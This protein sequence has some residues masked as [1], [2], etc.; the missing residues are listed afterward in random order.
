MP[1][2]IPS[3]CAQCRSRCGVTA[4]VEDGRLVGI[5]AD[6]GHPSGHKICPKGRAAPELVYAPERLLWPLQRTNPKGAADPGWQRISW[7]QA[8]ATTAERLTGLKARHGARGVAFAITSP[9]ATAISDAIPWVERLVHA[10]GSPN[11]IYGTEICNWHK[12]EVPRFT[13]GST[14][15]VPDYARSRCILLWGHNPLVT[16]LAQAGEVQ[17]GLRAGAKLIVVD[18]RPAGFARRADSWL[19]VRPGS[20]GALA[21]GL[22]NLLIESKRIDH[23]FL[24][25][26]TNGPF[27]MREDDGSLLR[28]G[29]LGL[30]G[31]PRHYV[32][33]R[34]GEGGIARYDAVRGLWP[35]EPEGLAPDDLSL[36]GA[37]VHPGAVG[38]IACRTAFAAYRDLCRAYPPEI[39]ERLTDVPEEALRRAADLLAEAGGQVAH[40]S[41]T[42]VGQH[43]NAS[44]TGRAISLLQA[45]TGSYDRV[46]A[47]LQEP[48][49]PMNDAAG[50]GL[51]EEDTKAQVLG[52]QRRPLGPG[53]NGWIT[54]RDAYGAMLED[55]PYAVRGLVGFGANLLLS[56]PDGDRGQE[57]LAGLDFYVHLDSVM[58]PTAAYADIVL[59]VSTGWERE[60]LCAGFACTAESQ[61][62]LQLK[63]AVIAPRGEARSDLEIVFDLACRLG[64][65]DQFFQGDSDAALTWQ[66]A[67]T[68]VSLAELRAN[69]AG[70]RLPGRPG[71]RRYALPDAEGAPRGFATPSRRVEIW[72]EQLLQ[73]G[74]APLP[75]YTPPLPRGDPAF[76]LT[77]TTAKTVAFCHS[78]HR[79]VPALRRLVPAPQLELHPRTASERGIVAGALIEVTTPRGQFRARARLTEGLHPRT[80]SA[81]HGWWQACDALD[82]PAYPV[83]G[84]GTANVNAVVSTQLE[85]PI[86]GS[87]PLRSTP[88]RVAPVAEAAE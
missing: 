85:D 18:P 62:Y 75:V 54:A 9:S 64:L 88:C 78:Q 39:V 66:L 15:G 33:C 70:L 32:A 20:D 47:N 45:L 86:S 42:G 36:T 14:I 2:S 41:W 5:E 58:T 12:D 29:D 67:P 46:G 48:P 22:A 74:Q 84:E 34:A 68:G 56:Q 35:D 55:A 51:V 10:F 81:Q 65:G 37:C 23:D 40:Y 73:V 26:W 24:R 87:I 79:H 31:D 21:L 28:S 27:L 8:L 17:K 63:P 59:P 49:P 60:G 80:L 1:V 25:R 4:E 83:T 44:Q 53:R 69:P 43:L 6:R 19:R 16:W 50:W 3:Y 82:E 61:F 77:L 57:A 72:S 7:E 13:F 71:E 11:I 38:D 30:P 52:L 76:D